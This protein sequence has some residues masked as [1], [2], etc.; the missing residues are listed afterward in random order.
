MTSPRR[1]ARRA[2]V[3]LVLPRPGSDGADQPSADGARAVASDVE[4]TDVEQTDVAGAGPTDVAGAGPTAAPDIDPTDIPDVIPTADAPNVGPTAV[5]GFVPTDTPGVEPTDAA[6]AI[7]IDV[8]QLIAAHVQDGSARGIAAAISR[9]A[10]SGELADGT[11]LPT[12]RGLADRLGTSPTTVGDAWQQLRRLGVIEGRGRAGTFVTGL[13]RRPGPRRYRRLGAAAGSF[14]LDLSTGTPDVAL[15]PDLRDALARLD[16][17]SLTSSYLDQPV[18]PD[19]EAAVRARL[20]F[21]AEAVTVV[22]GALDAIDRLATARVRLG[23]RVLVENPAF[24]PL[25]DLLDLLGAEIVAL[26]LDDEGIV[27][28]SL[29]DGLAVGPTALFLQPRAHNPT[30]ISMS[31]TR[32]G[33]LAELVGD[34]DA[35]VIEDDHSGDICTAPDVSLGSFIPDQTVHITSF[36]KSYGPDLRLASVAG[37]SSIIRPLVDRRLLGPGWSSRLLQAV[38]VQLLADPETARVIDHARAT[39]AERRDAMCVA[40]RARGV[41]VSGDDGLNLWIETADEQATLVALASHGIAA[42]PGTPFMWA[43][44]P[45]EHIRITVGLVTDRH[46]E[47]AATIALAVGPDAP[48]HGTRR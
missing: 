29:A 9:L 16:R 44:E 19:L 28:A 20:P 25:L 24:P 1:A 38:L 3:D 35:L 2:R 30:G 17:T 37:P 43:P 6:D 34:T 5:A 48:R 22:D 41:H 33:A 23:D 21:D 47:L 10:S 36:S 11:R 12:V 39:Y 45:L 7:P 27:P 14:R 4:Q 40:L 46:D 13:V 8:A 26:R 15:L 42:A 18:L 32:A 31:T